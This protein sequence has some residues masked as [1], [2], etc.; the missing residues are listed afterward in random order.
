M[1][2]FP[3]LFFIV[4]SFF[5]VQSAPAY[6]IAHHKDAPDKAVLR[7]VFCPLHYQD[8]MDFLN[9]IGIFRKKLFKVSPFSEFE[10]KITF[11]YLNLSPE[12]E[13][14]VFKPVSAFPPLLVRQ[15]FIDGLDK[16]FK[17]VYKL[18]IIDAKGG[19]TCA[20]LS[21]IDKTSLLIVGRARYNSGNSFAKGFLHEL[22]HSLGL[23]EESIDSAHK[24]EPGY[25]NC[26]T[27]KKDAQEW[28]GDLVG[29]DSRV[30][31]ISGCSGNKGYIRPTIASL[32]NDA[33]KA[34]DFGPVNE[35]Y[36]REVLREG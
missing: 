16:K 14:L 12:E 1:K 36:L 21:Q 23:R 34:E 2:Y 11:S 29:R 7:L 13:K 22:G 20:E 26:A 24:P 28:W 32:M 30:N 17:S 5:I 4:S 15:D 31:Y 35:C 8:N 10:G 19:Q 33:D 27:S 25:P 9:D 18:V 3:V 6:T